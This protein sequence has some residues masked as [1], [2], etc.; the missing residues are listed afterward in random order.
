MTTSTGLL[1]SAHGDGAIAFGAP[2]SYVCT[3]AMEAGCGP[4]SVVYQTRLGYGAQDTKSPLE[5]QIR[6]SPSAAD[7]LQ[8]AGD[9]L[10]T[11]VCA[12]IRR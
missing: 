7:A 3:S 10:D 5:M 4:P 8:S 12:A 9:P 11:V 1:Q 6:L 2:S